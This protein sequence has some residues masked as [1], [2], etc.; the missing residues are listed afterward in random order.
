V[1]AP[2]L[3]HRGLTSAIFSDLIGKPFLDG[4]RG[5]AQYD[6]V[7]LAM[8]IARRLGKDVPSYV[9]SEQELHKQ[10]AQGGT[11]FADCQQIN[12]AEPGCVVLLRMKPNQHHLAFMVDDYRMIHTTAK[13]GCVIERVNSILWQ[14]KVIGFYRLEGSC[15]KV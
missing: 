4:A 12:R 13:T 5:P 15:L 9:S 8:E 1:T 6:C 10:L 7:G 3:T 2:R 14:R 11:S